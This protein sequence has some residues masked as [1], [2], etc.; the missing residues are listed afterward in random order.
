MKPSWDDA[1]E[2]AKWLAVDPD[3]DWFWYENKPEWDTRWDNMK[4]RYEYA[5]CRPSSYDSL[6][7]RS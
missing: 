2:W 5:G 6:E 1:P 3:G 7:S 4:G